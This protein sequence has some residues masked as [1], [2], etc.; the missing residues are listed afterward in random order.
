MED[1]FVILRLGEHV[2]GMGLLLKGMVTS[3]IRQSE[4]Q[5]MA[6]K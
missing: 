3:R 6:R 2:L 4:A 1:G 5:R